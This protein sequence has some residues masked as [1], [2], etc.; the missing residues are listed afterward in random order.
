MSTLNRQKCATL[1]KTQL[2]LNVY[3]LASEAVQASLLKITGMHKYSCFFHIETYSYQRP[4]HSSAKLILIMCTKNIN[5]NHFKELFRRHQGKPN[6]KTLYLYLIPELSMSRL[7]SVRYFRFCFVN[8]NYILTDRIT[9]KGTYEWNWRASM[10]LLSSSS[11]F[12]FLH[13]APIPSSSSLF[14][15]AQGAFPKW[16]GTTVHH[17]CCWH[18]VAISPGYFKPMH[19]HRFV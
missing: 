16:R 18:V 14:F 5:R 9:T 15:F 6:C 17:L 12:L 1:L 8:I 11:C 4:H 10:L 2:S 13:S 3:L 19:T 7:I